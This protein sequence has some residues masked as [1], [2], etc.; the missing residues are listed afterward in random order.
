MSQATRYNVFNELTDTIGLKED[1][2]NQIIDKHLDLLDNTPPIEDI[3]YSLTDYLVA[4]NMVDLEYN[5][6]IIPNE[7]L[8]GDK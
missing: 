6:G 1:I 4:D 2:A 8:Q 3:D 5:D 7:H